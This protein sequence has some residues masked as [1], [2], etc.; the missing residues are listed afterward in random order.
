MEKIGSGACVTAQRTKIAVNRKD[1]TV[2]NARKS[3]VERNTA[4]A[5]TNAFT[6]S[7]FQEERMIGNTVARGFLQDFLWVEDNPL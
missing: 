5:F 1:A 2:E 6:L 4:N 3:L 7:K